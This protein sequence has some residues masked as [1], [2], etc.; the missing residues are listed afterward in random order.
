MAGTACAVALLEEDSAL[1]DLERLKRDVEEGNLESFA[2]LVRYAWRKDDDLLGDWLRAHAESMAVRLDGLWRLLTDAQE[3]LCGADG[4]PVRSTRKMPAVLLDVR[5][6]TAEA[7]GRWGRTF[8]RI[9][10]EGT[11]EGESARAQVY[12]SSK[13]IADITIHKHN[14]S[15]LEK[16]CQGLD[17][18]TPTRAETLL[19]KRSRISRSLLS[20]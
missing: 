11:G 6:D 1:I 14:G 5:G 10:A 20:L 17:I 8:W 4:I 15:R 7:R 19:S 12:V 9:Y 16:R 18:A 3:L 13:I 2:A